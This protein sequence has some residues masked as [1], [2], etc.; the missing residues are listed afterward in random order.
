MAVQVERILVAAQDVRAALPAKPTAA[1]AD[2]IADMRAQLEALL[3]TGFVTATGRPRLADLARYIT[4][5][6]RRLEKLPREVDV[7]RARMLRVHQM[8]AAYRDLVSAL[9]P[10]RVAAEDVADIRWLI[11]ELRVSLFAQQLGTARPVSRAADLPRDRRHHS[12]IRPD[13]CDHGQIGVDQT[14][15]YWY[16]PPR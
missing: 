15:P 6:G 2:S 12:L 14:R 3:P 7:D 1:Q 13:P 10:A 4:A 5:I 8:Q 9:P 16:R 11:E